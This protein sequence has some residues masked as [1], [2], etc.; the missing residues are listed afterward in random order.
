MPKDYEHCIDLTGD[1]YVVVVNGQ[2][3]VRSNMQE[4]SSFVKANQ[5]T[6]IKERI[7]VISDSA[8][9]YEKI[10]TT[11]DLLTESKINDYKL[12]SVNGKLP[13]TSPIEVQG[14]RVFTRGIDLSDPTV[15]I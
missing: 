13:R 15:L 4:I 6:I 5:S 11:I 8:T 3:Y 2:K 10:V 14:T 9:S 7:S 1:N 12:V